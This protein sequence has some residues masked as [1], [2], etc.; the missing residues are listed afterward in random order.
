MQ[1]GDVKLGSIFFDNHR[2]EI[3][4]FQRPYV[5]GE[6]R[7]W[8][9][10]WTDIAAAADSV[11]AD[12]LSG[13]WPEEPPTYFLGAIV[14]KAIPTHPQRLGG[15]ML[16][17]GQQRLTT[18]QVMLA[19][20]RAVATEVGAE[21]AAGRFGEWVENSEKAVHEKWPDDKYKLWPLPQDRSEYLW[22]VR[23]VGDQSPCPDPAHR[24]CE[25]R[26]W[27][28]GQILRWA[29]GDGDPSDRLD[30][31]HSAMET[32]IALV[33]ITLEKTDNAQVIF[34][35]LNHRGVELSQ[36]DL[37]K[38]LLFRLVEEDQG[39]RHMSESLLVDHW[40]PLD[41]REWRAETV[42]GRIKRSLLDQ[43]VAYWLTLRR[44]EVVSVERL[45][46]EF[47]TWLLDGGYKA[48]DVIK[49][50]RQYA[51]LYDKLVTDPPDEP[52]A[53]LV[54]LV[55]ATKTNTA[56]PLLLWIYGDDRITEDQR[57]D[58][59]GALSSYLVRRMLCGL[60]TK[61]YNRLF[62]HILQS[63]R[64]RIDAGGLLSDAIADE[65]ARLAGE[66][67][68]WPGDGEFVAAI[69]GSNFYGLNR[70]RQRVFFAGIENHL[71]DDKA[72]DANPV[73]ACWEYLNI[74]HVMPQNWRAK[75]PLADGND[76]DLLARR[77]QA[78]NSV[79]N[80]T[81]TNGRLNS[82]MR[83]KAW[84]SKRLALQQKSTLLITTASILAAPPGVAVEDA[85]AWPTEWDETRIAKRRAYLV[86]LALEVWP[87]PEITP[88]AEYG[89]DAGSGGEEEED[90]S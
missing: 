6:E 57:R 54:D 89:D 37:V 25:A 62:V 88:A 30:A 53:A 31:L 50:I 9:P 80:L 11:V 4:M 63:A 12:M 2:Y 32:R 17:D 52:T 48:S 3:P 66:T 22:A 86:G 78:I 81:L 60:T 36:S 70:A 69:M 14:V 77:E 7:N 56:W 28:E 47:R 29:T 33:R 42:T 85:A 16:V 35:A 38:N 71:R 87:R 73:R 10:L 90:F 23:D 76:E 58:A 74:E 49:D 1:A 39:S 65:L 55:L 64:K 8:R 61:D 51:D 15:S 59:A 79:G 5:W 45:F 84:P 82:Q 41:G 68:N 18:L 75:W 67:R 34:E 20:A 24:I 72:E 19:A 46:D 43:V 13:D 26:S 83:D 40:L 27:F 44:G 21:S